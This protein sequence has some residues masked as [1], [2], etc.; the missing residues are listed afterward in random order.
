MILD[1]LKSNDIITT[2]DLNGNMLDRN[3]KSDDISQS[4]MYSLEE[5]IEKNKRLLKDDVIGAIRDINHIYH[6]KIP[7][8]LL[9]IYQVCDKE[10]FKEYINND[11]FFNKCIKR[12]DKYINEN[13]TQLSGLSK[14]GD[15]INNDT[16][17][18]KSPFA[19]KELSA[20]IFSFIPKNLWDIKLGKSF[21]NLTQ[22]VEDYIKYLK[23]DY[24]YNV[25]YKA[26]NLFKKIET[27]FLK[28]SKDKSDIITI[29]KLFALHDD[30]LDGALDQYCKEMDINPVSISGKNNQF[31]II[32]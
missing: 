22:E 13:F 7:V 21:Y 32:E 23:A 3:S 31:D 4:T 1:A 19:V 15:L 28:S 8:K 17:I 14:S 6:I 12:A 27:I 2:L 29:K 9:K 25:D 5:A 18:A 20:R 16:N 30:D 11:K 24:K 10:L 26:L